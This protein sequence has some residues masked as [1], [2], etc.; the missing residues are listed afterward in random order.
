[1]SNLTISIFGNQIFSEIIQELKIFSQY[2]VKYYKDLNSCID[3]SNSLNLITIFYINKANKKD[4]K[5]LG[6]LNFPLILII[7]S[8]TFKN[9]LSGEFVEILEKPIK[10]S[11]LKKKITFLSSKY[12]FKKG[13]LISLNDYTIDRNERKIK[14]NNI[15][16]QL[17]EKEVDFLVLFSESSEPINRSL[18]LKKVW[19][20]SSNS[21]THTVETH[22]HRLRKKI[23]EK[24]NDSNFI[25]NNERGYF[26]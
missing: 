7:D 25:K 14:K 24:F 20:Y 12:K 19:N 23:L 16:L 3:D 21:D 9:L 13:S 15:E 1:M 22:I 11:D 8:P 17:T 5:K 6:K 4:Y 26:I 10:I 18:V 2:K